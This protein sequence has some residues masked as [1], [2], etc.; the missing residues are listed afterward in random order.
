M[1][2]EAPLRLCVNLF[3]WREQTIC[4]VVLHEISI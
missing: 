1:C 4:N 2:C 3:L